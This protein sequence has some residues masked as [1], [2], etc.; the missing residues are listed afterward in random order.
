M[1]IIVGREDVIAEM[2]ENDRH[3]KRYTGL[4]VLLRET[5]K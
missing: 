2:V 4:E 1:V 3:L 5:D